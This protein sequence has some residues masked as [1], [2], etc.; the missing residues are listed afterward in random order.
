MS[1]SCDV[2]GKDTDQICQKCRYRVYCSRECQTADWPIHKSGC[3]LAVVF[4]KAC[5]GDEEVTLRDLQVDT[6]NRLVLKIVLLITMNDAS[7]LIVKSSSGKFF[8]A[9]DIYGPKEPVG[10]VAAIEV[11]YSP[12]PTLDQAETFLRGEDIQYLEDIP[13]KIMK[14]LDDHMK[15][16]CPSTG[17]LDVGAGT[18]V[19][20]G[21][22]KPL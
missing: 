8:Q 6:A 4:R 15:R 5:P 7:A 16:V 3:K 13:F 9:F 11:Q 14:Y 2:C 18:P 1:R 17:L 20:Q 10:K 22:L 21:V 19:L 12:C